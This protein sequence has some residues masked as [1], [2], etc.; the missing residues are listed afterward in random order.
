[1]TLSAKG[2]GVARCPTANLQKYD[3]FPKWQNFDTRFFENPPNPLKR[4]NL[5]PN[6]H[7]SATEN[8]QG[9]SHSLKRGNLARAH[10]VITRTR[11]PSK[12]R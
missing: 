11:T 2:V 4:G 6:K 10:A 5:I 7:C 12:R 3:F 8:P 9:F 1:M